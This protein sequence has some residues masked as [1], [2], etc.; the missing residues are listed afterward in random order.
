MKE[1]K[2]AQIPVIVE[3]STDVKR[4]NNGIF[5]SSGNAVNAVK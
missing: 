2:D 1:V 5:P 3:E 4:I